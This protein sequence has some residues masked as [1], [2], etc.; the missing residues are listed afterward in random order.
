[1]IRHIRAAAKA[2]RGLRG[3][4]G[5]T[6]ILA[7]A[8]IGRKVAG[9]MDTQHGRSLGLQ[10]QILRGFSV[11]IRRSIGIGLSESDSCGTQQEREEL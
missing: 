4:T 10:L 11:E 3:F 6:I 8:S 1:V 9:P 2:R 5:R 7:R